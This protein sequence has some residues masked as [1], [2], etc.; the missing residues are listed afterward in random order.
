MSEERVEH[1]DDE[2]PDVI[3]HAQ[4]LTA[5][6]ILQSETDRRLGTLR[7]QG[8]II[9]DAV[10]LNL[11]I[12]TLYDF[13]LGVDTNERIAAETSVATTMN[14]IMDG[15]ETEARRRQLMVGINGGALPPNLHRP[16]G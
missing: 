6:K 8:V 14:K 13:L 12:T 16:R 2:T 15:I 7:G 11:R 1:L 3:S 9:P 4:A 10:I 5:L